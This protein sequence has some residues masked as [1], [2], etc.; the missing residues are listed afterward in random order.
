MSLWSWLAFWR[1]PCVLRVVLVTLVSDKDTAI[2]GVLWRSRGAWLVIRD[3]ALVQSR[4]AP[5]KAD[6][7]IVIHRDNVAF[8]Q[9]LPR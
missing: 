1:P 5:M 7:E 6:G 2:Q 8:L 3:A 9:V 4:S